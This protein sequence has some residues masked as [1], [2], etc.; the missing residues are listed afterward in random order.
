LMEQLQML[1][2]S[3]KNGRHLDFSAG[4]SEKDILKYLEAMAGG[5]DTVSEDLH[6]FYESL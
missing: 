1:K 3:F 6:A 5:P 2:F 4:T